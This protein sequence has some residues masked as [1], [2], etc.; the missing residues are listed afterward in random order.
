M[1]AIHD[2]CKRR[3]QDYDRILDLVEDF[4]DDEEALLV[5][6]LETITHA[7]PKVF[8]SDEVND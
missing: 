3:P 2:F 6:Q 5:L 4:N 7:H 1:E 8:Y